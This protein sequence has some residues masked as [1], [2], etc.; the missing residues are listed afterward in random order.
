MESRLRIAGHPIHPVLVMFPLGL[1]ATAVIFDAGHLLG[2][3]AL[4]GEA[5]YWNIGAALCGGVIAASAGVVDLMFLRNG[6]S[7]KRAAVTHGLVNFGVLLMFL[8]ILM[9]RMGSTNR[10]AGGGLLAVELVVLA[11]AVAGAWFGGELVNRLGTSEGPGAADR[12][13]TGDRLGT[14]FVGPAVGHRW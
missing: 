3:P 8:V 12:T 6:T 4:L 10:T 5:A 2:G 9:L 1:F 13:G 11:G 7:A 14:A